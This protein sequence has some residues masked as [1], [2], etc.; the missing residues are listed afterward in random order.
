M[1]LAVAVT[2]SCLCLAWPARAQQS[3]TGV[4][5]GAR[6][7]PTAD[8]AQSVNVTFQLTMPA[9]ELASSEAMTTA[10]AATTQ[11]LY[12]IVN[13]ECD[14]LTAVLKGACRLSR[15]SITA[16]LNGPNAQPVLGNRAN[17]VNA[18]ANATYDIDAA[19]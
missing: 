6:I 18:N 13:H 5:V 9:P 12:D 17:F 19:K 4:S 2:L 15:L 3:G 14:V 16:N 10:M 11:S 7:A 8:K 1:K